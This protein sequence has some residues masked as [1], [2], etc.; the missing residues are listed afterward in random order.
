MALLKLAL[1][2]FIEDDFTLFAIHS[3]LEPYR[4]AYLLNTHLN[5]RFTFKNKLIHFDYYEYFDTENQQLWSLVANKGLKK[6]TANTATDLFQFEQNTRVYLLPEYNRV[7]YLIKIDQQLVSEE[8][9]ISQIKKIPKIITTF[10]IEPGTLKSKNNL[11]F[12]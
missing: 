2:D 7:D 1:D 5:T 11:I 4:I 6:N 8:N 10:A 9:I 3:T 12:Y